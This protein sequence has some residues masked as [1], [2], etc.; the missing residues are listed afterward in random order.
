MAHLL[1]VGVGSGGMVVLD[2]LCRTP[3][4]TR[5]TL[6]EPDVYKPHNAARHYF[7]PS[8]AGKSKLDLAAAWL[9]EHRPDL[10]VVL[11]PCDLLDEAMQPTLAAAAAE[12]TLGV[13]AVDNEPA[14]YHWDALMR[15]SGKPWTL[16]EVLSGGI[17]GF[18]HAFLPGGPCYGCVASHLKREIVVDRP[19]T[20]DYT[21][22]GGPIHETTIPASAAAI[23]AIA[24][25]HAVLTLGL[26]EGQAPDFTTVLVTLQAVPEVFPEAFRTHRL[27][28]ERLPECLLCGAQAATPEN[29][30]AAL[31]EALA[32]LGLP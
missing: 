23:H 27:R 28:W 8:A 4:L 2:L 11:L 3:S 15:R 18:V 30:D 26:L 25:L 14:K 29:L 32:R 13:C 12:C 31:A 16:G 6:I 1:Q 7:P 24:S 9:R 22:P 19:P 5:V 20:P 21:A 17:G 10:D